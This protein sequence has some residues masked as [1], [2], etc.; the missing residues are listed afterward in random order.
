MKR[1]IYALL[2]VSVG[3]TACQKEQQITPLPHNEPA[4]I[5]DAD[6]TAAKIS[7][8]SN[9]KNPANTLDIDYELI[10]KKKNNGMGVVGMRIIKLRKNTLQG[11]NNNNDDDLLR[12]AISNVVL[13]INNTKYGAEIPLN[14][15]LKSNGLNGKTFTFPEFAYKGDLEYELVTVKASFKLKDG[16]IKVLDKST[17][18]FGG[19]TISVSSGNIEFKE[20]SSFT[21]PTGSTVVVNGAKLETT[22][23]ILFGGIGKESSC[24]DEGDYM[25]LPNGH[26]TEQNP[27]VKKVTFPKTEEGK[28]MRITVAGDPAE[29]VESVWYKPAPYPDPNNPNVMIQPEAIEFYKSEPSDK[30]VGICCYDRCLT[31]ENGNMTFCGTTNHLKPTDFNS[32]G[33]GWARIT[34]ISAL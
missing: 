27:T 21:L 6:L 30:K 28:V 4:S 17:F 20:N 15:E 9:K 19:S 24:N 10:V 13:S 34:L 31:K 22:F 1:I 8:G 32:D 26:S 18:S 5:T 25:L 2:A 33:E 7:A 23:A 14:I 11:A 3:F 29:A 16:S 12:D